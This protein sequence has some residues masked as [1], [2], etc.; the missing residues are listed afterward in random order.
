MCACM[1]TSCL[2]I[3]NAY[4][5][6][7]VYVCVYVCLQVFFFSFFALYSTHSAVKPYENNTAYHFAPSSSH[8]HQQLVKCWPLSFTAPLFPV[9][10]HTAAWKLRAM[11][12]LIISV[13]REFV[14]Y[15]AYFQQN[16]YLLSFQYV[17][18]TVR[19][20]QVRCVLGWGVGGS[21]S[22]ETN[23]KKKKKEEAKINSCVH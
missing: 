11:A 13:A 9:H 15:C 3:Y 5:C 4:M 18:V 2:Q 21:L 8:T 22:P 23:K 1:H 10:S 17:W 16:V 7:S 14:F 12:M 20:W 19:N 6:Q